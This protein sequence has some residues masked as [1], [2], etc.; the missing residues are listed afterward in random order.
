M[1]ERHLILPVLLYHRNEYTVK[2]S[3]VPENINEK[4]KSWNTVLRPGAH[5]IF[6]RR[7]IFQK[8]TKTYK[9]TKIPC[10]SGE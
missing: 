6:N 4:V 7:V 1:T 10:F 8:N 3:T 9:C 2:L 5:I